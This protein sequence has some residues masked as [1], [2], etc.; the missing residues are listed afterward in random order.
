MKA[1]SE[2]GSESQQPSEAIGTGR[3]MLALFD[4]LRELHALA[5]A[6]MLLFSLNRKSAELMGDIYLQCGKERSDMETYLT[7]D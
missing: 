1:F 4:L 2:S 5:M 7:E 6:K 3:R